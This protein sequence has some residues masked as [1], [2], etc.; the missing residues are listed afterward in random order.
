[1]EEAQALAF[2][3]QQEALQ[4]FIQRA[5]SDVLSQVQQVPKAQAFGGLVHHFGAGRVVGGGIPLNY[6]G[7]A[8]V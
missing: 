5:V 7:L 6:E 2:Q 3:K 1:L 8:K 4:T